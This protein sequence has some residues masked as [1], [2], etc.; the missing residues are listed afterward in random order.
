MDIFQS[1]EFFLASYVGTVL[2]W[3]HEIFLNV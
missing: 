3:E 2:K 1:A